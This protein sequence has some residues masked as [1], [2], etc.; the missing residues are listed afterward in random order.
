MRCPKC[1]RVDSSANMI[2]NPSGDV[3]WLCFMCAIGKCWVSCSVC[4]RKVGGSVPAIVK[5]AE[6]KVDRIVC[7]SCNQDFAEI[8]D[9]E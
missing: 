7:V 5:F 2:Q 3:E 6:A 4:G 8:L 1:E 9:D